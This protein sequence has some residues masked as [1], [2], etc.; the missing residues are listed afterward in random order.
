MTN[1]LGVISARGG[2]K[3]VPRKNLFPLIDGEPLIASAIRKAVATEEIDRVVCVTDDEEIAA[4]ARDAGAEIP[5]RQPSELAQ[6]RV[7]LTEVSQY[8]MRA[9]DDLGF[10]ADVVV[11][12]Q[13][14]CPFMRRA[15]YSEAI[16][17]VVEDRCEVAAA[18]KRIEHEHPYRARVVDEDGYFS[19][20]I[21]DLPVETFHT[22][23]ELPVLYCTSGGLYVRQ[24]HLLEA[25]DGTDFALG[26]RR[27]G[28]V[29]DDIEAINIDRQIDL[30][31]AEFVL[32]TGRVPD[33]H[34]R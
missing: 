28:I 5:F 17:A 30:D 27:L 18:L 29:L 14:T 11:Q 19:N 3:G 12:I 13:P 31:F 16:A 25:Y 7:P 22:R 23:Q 4:V 8:T 33:D 10:R 21:T 9:M 32:R 15:H 20:F 34:L 2:S 1:V 24:R 26:D 6:D